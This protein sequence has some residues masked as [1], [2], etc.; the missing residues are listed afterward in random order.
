MITRRF[1]I[2]LIIYLLIGITSAVYA[3]D[4]PHFYRAT[5]L[6]TEP[7]I[8][9]DWLTTFDLFIS[10]SSTHTARN[11]QGKKVPLFD[12]YGLNN[13]Q[14]LGVNVPCKNPNNLGS[15][16]L[17]Q[18]SLLPANPNFATLSIGGKF[19]IIELDMSF[20][21]NFSHGFY[22]G[23]YLPVRKLAFS[24]ICYNDLSS[25]CPEVC[26]NQNNPI[27]QQFLANFAQTLH[28]FNLSLCPMDEW[29]VGDLTTYVGW[30]HN[31]L[32]S[33]L[34][35]IDTSFR[36][37]VLAP[38]GKAQNINQVF[39]LPF[40]YNKHWAI[41]IALD[42]AF[43]GCEWFTVGGHFDTLIFFDKKQCVR[44]KTAPYQSG[45]IKL[46]TTQADV[47]KGN[48]W[49]AGTYAK[50]DHFIGG[51]SLLFGYSFTNKNNDSLS[52]CDST[53]CDICAVNSD[54][55]LQ[56]FNMHT[57]HLYLDYDFTQESSLY[58]LHV[59]IF[60]NRIVGGERIF[61]TSMPGT[62][63]GLDCTWDF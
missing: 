52:I 4:N 19:E 35:F 27:W 32:G 55:M 2:H 58:G 6:F 22:A 1:K 11:C 9:H 57:L 48:Y 50:A 41:P 8:E 37:G 24:N 20:V 40:G 15:F 7:R 59:G 16:T 23:A 45:I 25:T 60:Y 33:S 30:T 43:G 49:I 18:L 47:Q 56:G 12:I 51:L 5:Y 34:D 14:E 54:E 28:A 53:V 29:G 3:Y 46:A 39:S 44:I 38:T 42:I 26:P 31:Y 13:M 17:S 62:V 10:A 36:I 61:N 63:V 21:Q